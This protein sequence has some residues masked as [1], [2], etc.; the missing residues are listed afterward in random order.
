MY[1]NVTE[2]QLE[3]YLR[4][5]IEGKVCPLHSMPGYSC[6][7]YNKGTCIY[8]ESC[9]YYPQIDDTKLIDL[10]LLA[11][12]YSSTIYHVDYNTREDLKNVVLEILLKEYKNSWNNKYSTQ[13][14][15]MLQEVKRILG[16]N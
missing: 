2:N 6:E 11:K 14:Q 5:E 9:V 8:E 16:Q 15:D 3:F 7:H 1:S 13:S 10:L 12:K 4:F